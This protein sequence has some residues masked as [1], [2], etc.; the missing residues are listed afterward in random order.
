MYKRQAYFLRA[1]HYDY[2]SRE[3]KGKEYNEVVVESIR[4]LNPAKPPEIVNYNAEGD[5]LSIH[6]SRTARI[7]TSHYGLELLRLSNAR[8]LNLSGP[9]FSVNRMNG[10]RFQVVDFSGVESLY[11]R[12]NELIN[13]PNLK[14]IY[15]AEDCAIDEKKLRK[16]IRS[17]FDYQV[18][19]KKVD[20]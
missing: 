4:L 6:I 16:V 10:V 20:E 3:K 12:A 7:K 15:I 1:L 19:V 9:S 14:R 5:S 11:A 13:C 17:N 18:S 2:L 8:K